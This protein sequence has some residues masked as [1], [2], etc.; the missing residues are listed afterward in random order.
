MRILRHHDE[1]PPDCR[2][3]AV[4]LGNFDGLHRGHQAVIGTARTIA[5][6]LN[7]GQ[8]GPLGV[9]TFDPHPRRLFQPDAPPFSLSLL[10]TKA[11]RIEHLGANFLYVQHFDLTFASHPA[12]WFV[13][14]VLAK[15]L[16]VRHVVIGEDYRFGKGRSGNPDMMRAMAKDLGFGVT[17][18]APVTDDD[19][20]LLSSTR[21]REALMA[22]RPEEATLVLGRPWEVDGRVEHGD[23]RGRLIGFPTANLRLGDYLRPAVGVYAVQAGVDAGPDTVWFNGVA[24]FGRRPTFDETVPLLEVHLFDFNGDL[25]HQHLRVRLVSFL[26]PER[27][28]DG[29]EALKAQIAADAEAAHRLLASAG[30]A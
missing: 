15:S 2:G 21:V 12:E 18:V 13:D 17:T 11:R 24:N 27:K 26:R 16:G 28:F 6:T 25:Y 4:A 10:R 3:G 22:G 19:G 29:L 14:T 20:G 1:V 5:Q 9:M 23:A 30:P 8:G 7:G